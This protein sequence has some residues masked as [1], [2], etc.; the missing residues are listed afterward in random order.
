MRGKPW[1]SAWKKGMEPDNIL[2]TLIYNSVKLF[3][4]Y[5]LKMISAY[6]ATPGDYCKSYLMC[7]V[8]IYFAY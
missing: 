2:M 8:Y 5:S 1:I 3:L 7:N 4:E 6:L